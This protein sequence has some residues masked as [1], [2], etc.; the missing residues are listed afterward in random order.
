MSGG[1]ADGDGSPRLCILMLEP[2]EE[3]ELLA[4][5]PCREATAEKRDGE[6]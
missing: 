1:A 4:S 3:K 6:E 5:S 2:K